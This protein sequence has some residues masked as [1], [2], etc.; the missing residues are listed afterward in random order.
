M[1]VSLTMPGRFAVSARNG[2]I[3]IVVNYETT[4][5]PNTHHAPYYPLVQP[6]VT[7]SVNS[8]GKLSSTTGMRVRHPPCSK[9]SG[10]G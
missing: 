9:C 5:Y 3:K 2:G 1:A 8:V 7:P 6:A 10:I 4:W